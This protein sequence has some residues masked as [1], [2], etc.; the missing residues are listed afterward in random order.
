MEWLPF[1]C[2]DTVRFAFPLVSATVPQVKDPFLKVTEPCGI[3]AVD[4]TIAVKVT[5]S[6][7]F[8]GFTEDVTD[9]EVG[10]FLTFC[11]SG[12]DMLPEN[13]VLPE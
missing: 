5:G 3:P 1:D 9:V 11:M 2:I 8:E 13:S 4:V 6:P 12:D 10:A 7:D